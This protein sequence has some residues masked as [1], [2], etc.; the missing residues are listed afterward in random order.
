M[1]S[2]GAHGGPFFCGPAISVCDLAF[3]N[4]ATELRTA[5]DLHSRGINPACLDS[6]AKLCTLID[7]VNNHPKASSNWHSPGSLSLSRKTLSMTSRH[8]RIKGKPSI[9]QET[10]RGNTYLCKFPSIHPTFCEFPRV[11]RPVD[12]AA[13]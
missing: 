4:I 2:Q 11:S 1:L 12:S 10:H 7:A 13:G 9:T 5:E 8:Q 6:F 3:H